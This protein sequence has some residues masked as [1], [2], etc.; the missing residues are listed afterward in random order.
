MPGPGGSSGAIGRTL[1]VAA[2]ALAGAFQVVRSAVVHDQL[3][4]RPEAA[5]TLW[6]DHPQVALALAMAE[7]GRAAAAGQAPPASALARSMAAARRAPLAVEPLLI[8][9]AL[10]QSEGRRNIAARLFAEAARRDPRSAAARYFLAQHH[11]SSGRPDEG[12]RHASVLVRLVRGGPATLVPA[13][14]QYAKSPGAVPTLQAMFA[15]DH[16]LRDLVLS[17]L[18]RDAQNYDLIV[19]LAGRA[20]GKP[21]PEGAPAWQR[22]LLGALIERGELA[23][24]HGLWLRISGLSAAPAGIFNPQFAKLESPPPFNW[25]FGGGD[26]GFAEPA[27]GGGL[28]VIYY[29][30]AN[31]QFASQTLLL[32][33]G[34]YELRMRVRREGD[35]AQGSGLAWTIGCGAAGDG[36]IN[37]PLGGATGA[38]NSI[39]GRFT[40]PANCSS[41]SVRLVGTARDYAPSE[42]L[43]IH[44]LQLVRETK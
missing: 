20:I 16:Q 10:A 28:Q 23:R 8:R 26:F 22:Q 24:A 12:L 27:A 6:P 42:Q 18:A 44:D 5:A 4:T 40:V 25:T 2:L 41:Q 31:A 11:L 39:A 29:G 3:A 32:P 17:D 30:R 14:S 13:I 35:G 7:I 43:T 19:A 1:V 36:L 37:L 15:R 9:G 21:G 38:A 33:P 34:S